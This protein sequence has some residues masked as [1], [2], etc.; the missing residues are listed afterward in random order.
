MASDGDPGLE[1]GRDVDVKVA[2]DVGEN[3]WSRIVGD[4]D[5][6]GVGE[7]GDDGGEGGAFLCQ[8]ARETGL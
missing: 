6:G 3:G 1:V 4:E 5:L 7:D 2:M 8:G